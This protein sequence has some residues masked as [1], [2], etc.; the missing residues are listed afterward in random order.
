M[1]RMLPLLRLLMGSSNIFTAKQ[2]GDFLADLAIESKLEGVTGQYF[3]E[4]KE[5][6]SSKESYDEAKQEDLWRWTVKEVAKDG[7]AARFERLA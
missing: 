3:S 4:R 5:I 1:P 2:S 7:E 6:P